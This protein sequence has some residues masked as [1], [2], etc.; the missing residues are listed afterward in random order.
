A[1]RQTMISAEKSGCFGRFCPGVLDRL[2]FIKDHVIKLYIL[3]AG[4]IPSESA[5]SSQNQVIISKSLY[6]LGA[7]SPGVVEH[8]KTRR[9]SRCFLL[10]VEDKGPRHYYKR[11]NRLP[12]PILRI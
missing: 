1:E 3:Q 11:R 8:A 2:S 5:I 4:D 6:T 10:P 9:E 7:F 12:E